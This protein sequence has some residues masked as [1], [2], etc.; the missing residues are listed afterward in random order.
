LGNSCV[1][2]HQDL[3]EGYISEKYYPNQECTFC[4]SNDIWSAILFDHNLTD[5]PL[6][7]RHMNVNCRECH[8]DLSETNSNLDQYFSALESKCAICH[9]NIHQ[10]LFAINGETDCVRCHGTNN[11]FPEKFD[12]TTTSFP[13]DGKHAEIDC[14]ECHITSISNEKPEVT[15]KIEKFECIDCH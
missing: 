8:F 12:H 1:E 14:K 7:G 4:H 11:W 9:E 5:W 13:L 15:Y 10:D 6:T 3:H 2:C